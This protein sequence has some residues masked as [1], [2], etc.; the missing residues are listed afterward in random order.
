MKEGEKWVEYSE[1]EAFE[2]RRGKIGQAEERGDL[3]VKL[4]LKLGQ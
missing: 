3:A 2:N 1:E 4:W